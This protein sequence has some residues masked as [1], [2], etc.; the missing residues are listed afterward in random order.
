MKQE[1]ISLKKIVLL[2]IATALLLLASCAKKTTKTKE[3]MSFDELKKNTLIG[4]EQKKYENATQYLEKIVAK[5]PEHHDAGKHKLTLADTYFKMGKYL[6]AERLYSNYNNNYPS[7]EKAEYA[8]YK[9]IRSQFYQTLKTD[10]DQT[11]TEQTIH[12]CKKYNE[13]PTFIKYLRF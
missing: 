13:N 7:D 4:L 1:N 6:S 2:P 10:C 12:I 11:A 8:Q 3:E 5:Y 9:A